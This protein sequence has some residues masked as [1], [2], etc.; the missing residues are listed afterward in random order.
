[1]SG[2]QVLK[3]SGRTKNGQRVCPEWAKHD[4]QIRGLLKHVFPKLNTR[5]SD[6]E[7]RE[8]A[9]RQR[10]RAGRWMRVIQLYFRHNM[11]CSSIAE[12]LGSNLNTVE[13]IVARIY[14]ASNGKRHN[15]LPYKRKRGGI[16]TSLGAL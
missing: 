1:M 4:D 15:G 10:A 11:T 6:S 5:P 16:R 12:E 13:K 14:K 3:T 2:H 9:D 7:Q 8:I